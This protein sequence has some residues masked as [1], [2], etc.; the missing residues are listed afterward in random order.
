MGM[1]NIEVEIEVEVEKDVVIGVES[2][3]VAK[4]GV[5]GGEWEFEIRLSTLDRRNEGFR[6]PGKEGL[7]SGECVNSG[8]RIKAPD[9]GA[10]RPLMVV[11][12]E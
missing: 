9:K 10:G 8:V 3:V 11:V 5:R 6:L 1:S 2:G 4:V 7:G 12:V